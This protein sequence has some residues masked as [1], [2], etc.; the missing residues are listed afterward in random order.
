[1]DKLEWASD[2]ILNFYW[3][4]TK[5]LNTKFLGMQKTTCSTPNNN[6]NTS[7]ILKKNC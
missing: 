5:L 3:V 2:L 1:M 6:K 4:S 7:A